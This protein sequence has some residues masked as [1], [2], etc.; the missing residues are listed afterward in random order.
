MS[1]LTA[2]QTLLGIQDS[3]FAVIPVE[4]TPQCEILPGATTGCAE[5]EVIVHETLVSAWGHQW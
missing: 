1:G 5:P 3:A 2:A 4:V